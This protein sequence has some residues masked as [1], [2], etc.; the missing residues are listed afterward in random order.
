MRQPRLPKLKKAKPRAEIT[1]IVMCSHCYC[2]T[3]IIDLDDIITE[4]PDRDYGET[5]SICLAVCPH[6]SS[7]F[8]FPAPNKKNK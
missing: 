8:E 4:P 3:S 2:K 1:D 7:Y 5:N 6:C